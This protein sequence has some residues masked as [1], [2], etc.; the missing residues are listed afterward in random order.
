MNNGV[1][2]ISIFTCNREEVIPPVRKTD[3]W[4][5]PRSKDE[6]VKL[7]DIENAIIDIINKNNITNAEFRIILH[8]LEEVEK[9]P[10]VKLKKRPIVK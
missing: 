6:Q 3:P 2:Y 9:D 4:R 8:D 10:I 1:I 5:L 7:N